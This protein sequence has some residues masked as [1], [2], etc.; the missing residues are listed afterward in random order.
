VTSA[1]RHRLIKPKRRRHERDRLHAAIG[2]AV[3]C[4]RRCAVVLGS[5]VGVMTKA[6]APGC[7]LPSGSAVLLS[8]SGPSFLH[9]AYQPPLCNGKGHASTTPHA[10]PGDL[11]TLS[12]PSTIEFLLAIPPPSKPQ[13]HVRA[14]YLGEEEINRSLST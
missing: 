14:E 4:E 7:S 11:R 13:Q 10:Q 12:E 8:S 5:V 6:D 1:A 2:S 3:G 9:I